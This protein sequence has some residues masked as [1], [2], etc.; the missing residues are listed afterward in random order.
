MKLHSRGPHLHQ[1]KSWTAYNLRFI[2]S[3][4]SGLPWHSSDV[5]VVSNGVLSVLTLFESSFQSMC[6]GF[7]VWCYLKVI[8]QTSFV[9][10]QLVVEEVNCFA[11]LSQVRHRLTSSSS[12]FFRWDKMARCFSSQ[13]ARQILILIGSMSSLFPNHRI[14]S[15]YSKM[16]HLTL[17]RWDS[18]LH[19]QF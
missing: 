3:V 16:S 13:T 5:V 1:K 10:E 4:H 6:V 7:N 15:A 17:L 12:L 18:C 8:C 9:L 11:V 14:D 2:R 19:C